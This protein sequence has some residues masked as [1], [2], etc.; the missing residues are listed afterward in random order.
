MTA[1]Q[2]KKMLDSVPDECDIYVGHR[3]QGIYDDEDK[4]TAVIYHNG[5]III[6]KD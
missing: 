1:E 6:T 4:A 2:L 5:H 3:T